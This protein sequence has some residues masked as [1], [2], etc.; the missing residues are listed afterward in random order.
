M[1]PSALSGTPV[2]TFARRCEGG[3]GAS[4]GRSSGGL[5]G[6]GGDLSWWLWLCAYR[7]YWWC[8]GAGA[9]TTRFVGELRILGAREVFCGLSVHCVL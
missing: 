8:G 6:G 1:L 5:L 3:R 9:C 7:E 2:L 4:G